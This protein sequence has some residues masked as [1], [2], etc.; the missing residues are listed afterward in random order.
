MS[1]EEVRREPYK[2]KCACGCGFLRYYRVVESNDWGQEQDYNTKVEIH[3]VLCMGQYHFEQ[4]PYGKGF[5]VPNGL[6]IPEQIPPLEKCESYSYDEEFI[7]RF[8]KSSVEKMIVDMTAPKHRFIKDLTYEPAIVW[9]EEWAIRHK[10]R[11]LQPMID[12][13]QKIFIK[14][15]DLEKSRKKKTPKIKAHE[16]QVK[17]RNE[18]A[19]QVIEQSFQPNF[20]YDAEQDKIDHEKARKEQEEYREAHRFDPF[21]ARVSYDDSCKVDLTGH[22]WDTLSIVQ[23]ID[24]QFLILDKPEYGSASITIVKKYKCKCIICGKEIIAESSGFRILYDEDQGFYPVLHC[25]CHNVTSFEAKAMDILNNFGISYVREFS[26]KE[27]VGDFGFPLRFDFALFSPNPQGNKGDIKIRLLLE[28][29]GPHHYMQGE[30]DEFGEFIED[31]DN[32]S[33]TARTRTEKQLRY[34]SMKRQYCEEHKIAL[35]QIK[36]TYRDYEKLETILRSILLK[37]GFDIREENIPF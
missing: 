3:C 6:H 20:S 27:L 18:K 5:L 11:S 13:L 37:Y 17:E 16:E 9:A 12:Y 30:Y 23:C 32:T 35:E 14:Y 10:K 26:I 36:Y 4:E 29:Q 22:Y 34:D 7:G 24:P 19:S 2:S 31:K 21:D 1:Y 28:L 25:K 8:E 15:D 33:L